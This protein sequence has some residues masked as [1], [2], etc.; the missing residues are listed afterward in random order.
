MTVYLF[1][2]ILLAFY[3]EQSNFVVINNNT[4]WSAFWNGLGDLFTTLWSIM[5]TLGNIPNL[6]AI[7]IISVFFIYWTGKLFAF[8]KEGDA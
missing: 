8:K 1:S 4:M 6:L 5:P 3:N 2:V 7:L